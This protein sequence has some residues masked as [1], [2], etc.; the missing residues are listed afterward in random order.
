MGC[1]A[2]GIP[3]VRL[4]CVPKCVRSGVESVLSLLILKSTSAFALACL[5][6]MLPS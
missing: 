5:S 6:V 1:N 2:F 3:D 4:G